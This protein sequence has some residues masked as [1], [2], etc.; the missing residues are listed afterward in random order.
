M[1]RLNEQDRAAILASLETQRASLLGA[2]KAAAEERGDTQFA[3]VLGR[4]SGDSGDEALAVTLGDLNAARLD[5]ELRALQ[6]LDTARARL[7]ADDYGLCVDCGAA[8]PLPRLVANPAATR[9]VACQERHE[10]TFAGQARGS[11]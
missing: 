11:L 2:L 10:H 5:H 7:D 3:E 4:A 6:A 9:C 1:S 8:I